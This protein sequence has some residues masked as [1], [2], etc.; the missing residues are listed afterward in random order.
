MQAGETVEIGALILNLGVTLVLLAG[1]GMTLVGLPGN[2]AVFL[3]A[4]GYGLYEGFVLMDARF[5]A[6]LFGALAL[7]EVAEFLSGMLGARREKASKR[8]MLGALFGGI[9]GALVG[10]GVFPVVGSLAGAMLGAFGLSYV[11]EMSKSGD[12][13]KSARVAKSAAIGL[14]AGTL[15][16]LA[17]GAGMVA[18]VISRL[19]W[20]H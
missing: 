12:A 18:A 20:V 14:V 5:L 19:P 13:G 6:L 9:A 8:A 3:T 2:L 11:A 16:K 17:V 4:A 15:L 10:T 1:L 7:G